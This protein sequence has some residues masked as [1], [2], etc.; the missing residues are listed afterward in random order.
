MK[1]ARR[2]HPGYGK[3]VIDRRGDGLIL[4]R[5]NLTVMLEHWHYDAW[6]ARDAEG[7]V[8]HLHHPFDP[9]SKVLF[10]SDADGGIAAV[11][12]RLEPAVDP[13]RFA[14]QSD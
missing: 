13:I 10:E 6:A 4:R 8:I 9:C 5:G 2:S 3:V 14:K 7:F 12:I 11:S 1:T